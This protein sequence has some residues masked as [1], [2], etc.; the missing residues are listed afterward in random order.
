MKDILF[1]DLLESV[2]EGAGIMTEHDTQNAIIELITR[3]GGIAIRINSGAIPIEGVSKPYYFRGAKKGTSDIIALYKGRFLA[4][5]VKHGK[6]TA[7]RE[8]ADFISEVRDKGGVGLCVWS[9]DTV[10]SLLDAL[11]DGTAIRA[12]CDYLGRCEG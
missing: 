7:S 3:R 12:I 1:R 2:Q 10:I 8:Q 6:N 4:I 11:D 9:I 5:E